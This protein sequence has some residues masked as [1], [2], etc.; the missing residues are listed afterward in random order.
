MPVVLPVRRVAPLDLPEPDLKLPG[1]SFLLAMITLSLT[2]DSTRV[3]QLP[4]RLL[5]DQ[6]TCSFRLPA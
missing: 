1:R 6:L 3:Y 2:A 5:L 4:R